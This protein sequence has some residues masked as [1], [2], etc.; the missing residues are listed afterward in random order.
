MRP[1][2]IS[3]TGTGVSTVAVVDHY[4]VPFNIGLGLVISGTITVSIQHTFDNILDSAVT[5]TWFNHATIV[6]VTTNQDGNYAF[7]IRAIRLNA[8][9][10]TGTATLTIIQAGPLTR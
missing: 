1:I 3:R 8:T 7:P 2:V 6:G 9:A 5:P 4:Q 10:G